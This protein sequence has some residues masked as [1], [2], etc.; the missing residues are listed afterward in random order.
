MIWQPAPALL[1]VVVVMMVMVVIAGF[2]WRG[3][4]GK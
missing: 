2:L 3:D 1:I 4:F